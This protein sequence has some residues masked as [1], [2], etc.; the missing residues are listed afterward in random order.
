MK[1]QDMSNKHLASPTAYFSTKLILK[2]FR[3]LMRIKLQRNSEIQYTDIYLREYNITN[4]IVKHGILWS[5]SLPSF[6][7]N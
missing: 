4:R 6:C 2:E 5:K 7:C 3:A 1:A